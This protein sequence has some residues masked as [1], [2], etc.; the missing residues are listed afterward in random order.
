MAGP[1]EQVERFPAWVGRYEL[2]L[3][4]ASG[5][6]ATV[7]LAKT[8]G[9][10]GFERYVALKLLHQ[11]LREE[12][13]FLHDLIEEAKLAAR[14]RHPNVVPVLDVGQDANGTFL[15]MEYV[16]GTSLTGLFRATSALRSR[17]APAVGLRIL[18]DALSGLHAA[19]EQKDARGNPLG[20]VHRD[21][22]PQNVLVGT[23]GIARL[24]D[25]GIA[26]AASR[27][28]NTRTGVAKGK[29]PYMSP[30]QI[31]SAPLDRRSDIWSAGV[32]AWEL[33]ARRRL[34]KGDEAAIVLDI[35]NK[36]I[37]SLLEIEPEL[38]SEMAAAIERALKR[39]PNRR[40]ETAKAF[41][42]ELIR[43]A[44]GDWALADTAEVASTVSELMAEEL[45]TRRVRVARVV[46]LREKSAGRPEPAT[47]ELESPT[48][49]RSASVAAEGHRR[50]RG[51]LALVF[52]LLI[53]L[54]VGIVLG[55]RRTSSVPAKGEPS[56]T[57]LVVLPSAPP[58]PIA[59]EPP[60]R[61]D[62]APV[63]PSAA[64][65]ASAV[66]AIESNVPMAAVAVD[67]VEQTVET[68]HTRLELVVLE[69]PHDLDI[70]S[71]D[72]RKKRVKSAEHSVVVKFGTGGPVPLVKNPY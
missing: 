28:S 19:H 39:D 8:T 71:Q 7:Y 17:L 32:M 29:L 54:G 33:I 62:V 16:E 36:P 52:M 12:P 63:A 31:R 10:E 48:I 56:A 25:F 23:D 4:I 69:G 53:G 20:L 9:V 6:M 44:H 38:P 58:T 40:I 15:A 22:T 26:K 66:L 34:F 65:A 70:R 11:H 27:I 24:T 35:I 68:G 21:F 30:E 72:G 50:P 45:D 14:I 59:A 61:T 43:A 46:H 3:P 41:R 5:G 60:A 42:D 64:P 57:A 2:L 37:P 55:S 1:A 51:V 18:V 67:G 47:Q 49:E 13:T